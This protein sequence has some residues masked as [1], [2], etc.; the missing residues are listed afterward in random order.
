MTNKYYVYGHYRLDTNTL[1]YVGKGTGNRINSKKSRNK[2]W[3]R[4]TEKHGYFTFYFCNEMTEQEAWD[5][6]KAIIL[7]LKPET[8]YAVG[9]SG[10][11]TFLK[12]T[13]EQIKEI[14]TKRMYVKSTASYGFKNKKHSEETKLKIKEKRA[15]QVI[16]KKTTEQRLSMSLNSVRNKKVIDTETLK[17]FEN[18]STAADF[19][20]IKKNTLKNYLNG[21]RKNTTNLRY[22]QD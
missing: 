12:L 7:D 13:K 9:G 11:N 2:H 16:S 21:N 5:L 22:L 17:I 8:N 20:K 4:I 6:E 3:K 18:I 10:G 19:Y 14:M 15:L 1:F